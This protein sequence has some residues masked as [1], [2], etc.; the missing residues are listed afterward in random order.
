MSWRLAARVAASL[1]AVSLALP[2]AGLAQ[3]GGVGTVVLDADHPLLGERLVGATARVIVPFAGTR[4]SLRLGAE[5]LSG[6]AGRTGVPCSGLIDPE[7]CPP[8][9]LRDDARLTTVAGGLG[10]RVLSWRGVAMDLVGD[11]RIGKVRADTRGLSSGTSLSASKALRGGEI[12]VEGIWSPWA[13]L[14]LVLEAGIAASRLGPVM[15]EDVVDGYTPFED[16]FG[17]ARLRLGVAWR[18]GLR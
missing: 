11:L 2:T 8:E 13:P 9:P 7:R 3:G 10:V 14:P 18:P 15:R 16:G 12:G 1:V 17:A 5:R 4:L 6:N